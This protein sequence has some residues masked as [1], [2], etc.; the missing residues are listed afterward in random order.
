M[1]VLANEMEKQRI[2]VKRSRFFASVS[3]EICPDLLSIPPG[4]RF[5]RRLFGIQFPFDLNSP[6]DASTMRQHDGN[7]VV[8]PRRVARN[9][10]R[11]GNR[12]R[13]DAIPRGLSPLPPEDSRGPR[14][15]HTHTFPRGGVHKSN[16]SR[17]YEPLETLSY[18]FCVAYNRLS[19]QC[20]SRSSLECRGTTSSYC[21]SQASLRI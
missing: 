20:S 18:C 5:Q 11:R 13:S 16:V 3:S 19:V 21:S 9:A 7:A 10:R 12:G 15:E 17:N 14:G 4:R 2:N 6:R 8:E 1:T